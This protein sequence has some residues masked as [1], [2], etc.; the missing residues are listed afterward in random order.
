[1]MFKLCKV[2]QLST[3][4]KLNIQTP[5]VAPDLF[6]QDPWRHVFFRAREQRR[7][8]AEM[9][10]EHEVWHKVRKMQ[11]K[12][13]EG[14]SSSSPRGEWIRDAELKLYGIRNKR[15]KKEENKEEEEKEEEKEDED[16][17]G[18]GT[19]WRIDEVVP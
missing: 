17:A 6:L 2:F 12:Y 8:N 15:R 13:D 7:I 16:E 14:K 10:A 4:R 19:E 9:N 5:V 11:S 18:M 3:A 1:M